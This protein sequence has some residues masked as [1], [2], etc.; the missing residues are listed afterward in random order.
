MTTGVYAGKLTPRPHMSDADRAQFCKMNKAWM[1][2]LFRSYKT[3]TSEFCEATVPKGGH[4]YT[5]WSCVLA[6]PFGS[7]NTAE[8]PPTSDGLGPLCG[9]NGGVNSKK[10]PCKLRGI[11]NGRCRHHPYGQQSW[12]EVEY[13]PGHAATR[14]QVIIAADGATQMVPMRLDVDAIQ[15]VIVDDDPH[16]WPKLDG[17]TFDH[18]PLLCVQNAQLLSRS[19]QMT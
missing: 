11:V 5:F 6:C 19:V 16:V 8:P 13:E 12:F 7:T 15:Q 10:T 14:V 2:A 9:D 4:T 17:K 3:V 18:T 1:S